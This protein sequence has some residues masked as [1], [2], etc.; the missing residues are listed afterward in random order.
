MNKFIEAII[1]CVE[2]SDYLDYTLKY[3]RKYFD[4]VI[5]ITNYADENAIKI[6]DKYKCSYIRTDAFY[7]NDDVFNKGRAINE[8]YPY[9]K[10]EDW[11]LN[12]DA[13]IILPAN[14]RKNFLNS[15]PDVENYYWM[16]RIELASIEQIKKV[17]IDQNFNDLVVKCEEAALGFFQLYNYSSINFIKIYKNSKNRPY[18]EDFQDASCSDI[19]FR[20]KWHEKHIKKI[21]NTACLHLGE[22]EKNWSCRVTPEFK[23]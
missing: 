5:I 17:T 8:A 7:E 20:A 16:D 13:D 4:N 10:H 1:V 11:V 21:K 22:T 3:N 18:P 12:L 23:L 6:A 15:N 9:L 14:F 19:F 2:Y